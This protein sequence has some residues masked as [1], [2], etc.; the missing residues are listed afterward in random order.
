MW[1][2]ENWVLPNSF[3][4]ARDFPSILV[5]QTRLKSTQLNLG[6]RHRSAKDEET[7]DDGST[8]EAIKKKVETGRPKNDTLREDNQYEVDEKNNEY[9][10]VAP[11]RRKN[12]AEDADDEL[13]DNEVTNKLARYYLQCCS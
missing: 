12:I 5:W 8:N 9:Q 11:P 1:D 6:F 10:S 3:E 7:S 13:E 2:G 4:I